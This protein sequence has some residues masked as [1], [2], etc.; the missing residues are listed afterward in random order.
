[1]AIDDALIG[2]IITDWDLRTDWNLTDQLNQKNYIITDWDLRAGWKHTVHK[3]NNKKARLS[4]A[5]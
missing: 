2:F 5:F 3:I 1:M 4:L